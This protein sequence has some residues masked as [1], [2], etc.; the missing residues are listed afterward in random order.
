M[1]RQIY[2]RLGIAHVRDVIAQFTANDITLSRASSELGIGKTR[3]Y[4]LRSDYLKSRAIGM[5]DSWEPGRSGGNH[6]P[7]WPTEVTR[8]LREV[9]SPHAGCRP[10]TYAFA[11][12]EA[13]R[14]FDWKLD[15][16]QVRLWAMAH[17]LAKPAF[18]PHPPAYVRRW[19]RRSVGELWQLDATP[20]RFFGAGGPV[21][22]LLDM[23][24]DCSRMQV[25]CALY[26][27]ESVAAYL[28][29]FHTAFTRYGLPLEIYVDKA[30]FFR[31]PDG[32]LTQLAKR[33]RFY[34]V[35]FLCANTPEA[36]GKIE[37]VHQ[38]W[39]DRLPAYFG[40]T[41]DAAASFGTANAHLSTLVDYRNMSETHREIGMTP[42]EAWRR[43]VDEGRNKLR[44]RPDDKW[45]HFV[46]S[47]WS[48]L[49]I[50]L[51]GR[52]DVDG[53]TCPTQCA[54]GTR[55]YLCRHVDGSFSILLG[56]PSR[57]TKPVV[58]FSTKRDLGKI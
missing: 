29:L 3:L 51:R 36:K 37:R 9:L 49:R 48:S 33:L 24:D 45:W 39:Q 28:H 40:H 53:I 20:D 22:H 42:G 41:P 38:V 27:R 6:M 8:F 25:G 15:R 21:A 55:A 19:Q 50:G 17:G 52:V 1:K 13:G 23:L 30:S 32:S 34:D 11:A 57:E 14:L 44:P 16:A 58:L 35:S 10:Y 5:A 12:S 18:N 7:E 26:P 2:N 4:E 43:A 31:A 56:K 47:E 54:N 46:W